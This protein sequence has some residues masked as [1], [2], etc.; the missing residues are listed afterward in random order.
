MTI[1]NF[2]EKITNSLGLVIPEP[3]YEGWQ[4]HIDM[5]THLLD[6]IQGAKIQGHG[7]IAGG[8]AG[9]VLSNISV[10]FKN[11]D[12]SVDHITFAS[13]AVASSNIIDTITIQRDDGPLDVEIPRREIWYADKISRTIKSLALPPNYT[14]FTPPSG[15][16]PLL[17]VGKFHNTAVETIEFLK[18]LQNKI[19]AGSI[20][21]SVLINSENGEYTFNFASEGLSNPTNTNYSVALQ[22]A[23][24]NGAFITGTTFW[25][26]TTSEFTL[27][28]VTLQDNTLIDNAMQYGYCGDGSFCGDGDYYGSQVKPPGAVTRGLE[29]QVTIFY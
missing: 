24:A 17:H 21:K 11:M 14:N 18:F 29:L 3:E 25:G 16:L 7:L 12:G 13:T 8:L 26:K 2:T 1:A 6:W 10:E 19:P 4:S 15:S 28:A 5:N 22:P 23:G 20:T 9:G 27:Q